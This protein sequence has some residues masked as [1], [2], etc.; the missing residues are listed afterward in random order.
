MCEY[1]GRAGIIVIDNTEFCV[2]CIEAYLLQFHYEWVVEEEMEM[3]DGQEA[4]TGDHGD[5]DHTQAEGRLQ[6]DG[7]TSLEAAGN[8]PGYGVCG[9]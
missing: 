9:P 6:L 8:A 4:G 3:C 2:A 1:H 5:C 7:Q